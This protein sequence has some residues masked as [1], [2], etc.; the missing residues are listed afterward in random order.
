MI[1]STAQLMWFSNCD[2]RLTSSNCAR[3]SSTVYLARG[4]IS[5]SSFVVYTW[6]P[7]VILTV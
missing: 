2:S 1:V 3:R 7:L 6:S 4:S 5:T